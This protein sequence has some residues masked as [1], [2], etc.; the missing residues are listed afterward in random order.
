MT[1]VYEE[2]RP[3]LFGI[4]YRMLG[5]VADAEDV[6][7]E[8]FT[9]YA[10]S[11]DEIDS[12]RAWLSAVTTRLAIDQL[13]SARVRREQYFGEWLP[14]P[15]VT[16]EPGPA[17]QAQIGDSL[18]LAFL[19]V[20]ETLSPVERAVFLLH[21]VFDY[22]YE[23][24]APIV[25]KTEENCRQIA[26]RARRHVEERR[27]RFDASPER[28]EELADRFLRA[29]QDGDV[30][31]LVELLAEDVVMVGDG[32]GKAPA[33][34]APIRGRELA[35]QAFVRFTAQ[36]VRHGVTARA[37]VVNGQPGAIAYDPDGRIVS[38]L[39]IDV[40]DGVI[41]AIHAVINPDKLGHLGPVGDL[42]EL[43]R[44]GPGR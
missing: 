25:A 1:N 32:G 40:G 6:V 31:G 24:I 37:A 34:P 44:T 14:E 33:A 17:E 29:A 9:R 13:R 18:S 7:Q 21:D 26:V 12:P 39:E 5:S 2:L 27:P 3:L 41:T 23:E 20:L 8:A 38:V 28:R 36:A 15:L 35:A 42:R 11:D 19:V 16:D 10:R 43:Y 30:D 22:G 4:A